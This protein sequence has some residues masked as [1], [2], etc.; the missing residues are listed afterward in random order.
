MSVEKTFEIVDSVK[1]IILIHWLFTSKDNVEQLGISA[2][3]TNTI[4]YN[5]PSFS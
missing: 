4:G 1:A 3:K 2:G 5:D